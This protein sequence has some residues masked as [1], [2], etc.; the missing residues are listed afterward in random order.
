MKNYILILI[1]AIIG[2]I[3]TFVPNE[4]IISLGIGILRHN[5]RV[6][7]GSISL[8]I[9]AVLIFRSLRKKLDL[10]V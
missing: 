8:I 6:L 4:T 5:D 7:I 1:F 10:K 3:Y 2:I 9:A